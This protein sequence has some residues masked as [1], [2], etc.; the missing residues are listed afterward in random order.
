MIAQPGDSDTH[1]AECTR[2]IAQPAIEQTAGELTEQLGLDDK[3]E[4]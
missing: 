4:E 3:D 2:P 1:Q